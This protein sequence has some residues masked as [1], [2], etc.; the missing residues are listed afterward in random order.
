MATETVIDL[1]GC[2]DSEN[3]LR[4]IAEVLKFADWFGV[5]WDA[6]EECMRCL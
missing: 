3:V 5:N 6:L 4:K 1:K 2:G